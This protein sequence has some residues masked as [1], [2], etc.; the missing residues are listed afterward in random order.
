MR[1]IP[2]L[3]MIV[4]LASCNSN[5]KR[6]AQQGDSIVNQVV[7]D[8]SKKEVATVLGTVAD[9]QSAYQQIIR[10][11]E[12]KSLDSTSF[13]YD[14][15][16]ETG[17]TVSY[18]TANGNLKL[19]VRRYHE[20]DHHEA[21]ERYFVNEDNL[22]FLHKRS[23]IWSFDSGPEGATRDQITE[24]RSYLLNDKAVKCLEKKYEIRKHLGINP[25]P[26]SIPN[27][28]IN[29]KKFKSPLFTFQKLKLY[30]KKEPPTC[31]AL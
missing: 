27:K 30:W 2:Y 9:I 6:E 20:Y 25:N 3:I 23:L 8:T 16:G 17:G 14:C 13:K 1:V 26:D 10:Q 31:L 7:A 19:I 28:E 15:N 18:F 29:C 21:E 11:Y 24:Q 5:Q 22:Y 12:N 4:V